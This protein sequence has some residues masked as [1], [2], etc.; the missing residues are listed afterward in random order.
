MTQTVINTSV[1]HRRAQQLLLESER[2]MTE[3]KYSG[4]HACGNVLTGILWMAKELKYFTE[5]DLKQYRDK[6]IEFRQAATLYEQN[7]L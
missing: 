3:T 4:V 6:L 1:L 7:G 2:L 5:A